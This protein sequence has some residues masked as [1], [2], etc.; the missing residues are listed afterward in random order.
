MNDYSWGL[1]AQGRQHITRVDSNIVLLCVLP[2][3]SVWDCMDLLDGAKNE[4]N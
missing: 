1:D 4:S 3:C 2:G